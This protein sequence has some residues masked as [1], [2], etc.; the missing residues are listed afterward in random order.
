[1]KK[2]INITKV[3][4]I[5]VA[6][7]QELN[8]EKTANIYNVYLLNLSDTLIENIMIT[9]RG[10]GEN[11]STGDQTKTSVLRHKFDVLIP[12]TFMKIE[13]IIEDLFKLNNEYWVSFFI[14]NTMLDKKF[15]FLAETVQESN[16]IEILNK[17]GILIS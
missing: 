11:I 15:I 9:S 4:N 1:M 13:P 5:G 3:E 14:G 2:D 12:N 8:D 6:I 7:V 16:L 17:R 10:Y